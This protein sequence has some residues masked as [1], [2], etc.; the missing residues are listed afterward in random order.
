ML[1]RSGYDAADLAGKR[2][3]QDLFSV[4]ARV[5][6]Q[7][8]CVPL[9]QVRGS[10]A[11]VQIEMVHHDRSR[12][13]VLMNVSRR[14]HGETVLDE[15]AFFVVN[16]RRSYERELLLARKSA[17]NALTAR[18]TAESKLREINEQLQLADRRKDEFLAT[19]AHELR[20]PLAPMRNVLEIFKRQ[21]GNETART[22]ALTSAFSAAITAA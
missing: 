4:G 9:L 20:N 18:L 22:W 17:E 1:F 15:Y 19:L 13:P 3:I 6:H 7:T 21:A 2:R 10:I 12:I 16:D 8:H 5:F 14:Q 11:E